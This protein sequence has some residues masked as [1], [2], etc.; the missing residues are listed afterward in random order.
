MIPKK[1]YDELI[2]LLFVQSH[3]SNETRMVIYLIDQLRLLG[4]YYTI[5]H[6]GNILV[7]KSSGNKTTYPCVR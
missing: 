7:T 2:N 5:D 1:L 3:F 4:L 6:V